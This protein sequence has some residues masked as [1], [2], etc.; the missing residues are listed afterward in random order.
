[1]AHNR[2]VKRKEFEQI[3]GLSLDIKTIIAKA[4]AK[5]GEI[6][7]DEEDRDL[8]IYSYNSDSPSAIGYLTEKAVAEYYMQ[9]GFLVSSPNNKT[10]YDYGCDF[11][12][13]KDGKTIGVRTR[14][15]RPRTFSSYARMRE[16]T[17]RDSL[18]QLPEN[19]SGIHEVIVLREDNVDF[20]LNRLISQVIT[21]S[22][23]SGNKE[24]VYLGKLNEDKRYVQLD[25][26]ESNKEV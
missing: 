16:R 17:Q 26:S 10:A 3:K 15:I 7:L 14:S 18:L 25:W 21:Y 9:L 4:T 24:K 23:R 12:A 22:E 13:E 11:L 6:D 8:I 1:V 5:L 2:H 19:I 20:P